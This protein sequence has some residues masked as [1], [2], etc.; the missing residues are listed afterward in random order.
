MAGGRSVRGDVF[1]LIRLLQ[2][3]PTGTN[4]IDRREEGRGR[5]RRGG[6]AGSSSRQPARAHG[7]QESNGCLA[8]AWGFGRGQSTRSGDRQR[9]CGRSIEL[10]VAKGSVGSG[11][12][13][14]QAELAP[15]GGLRGSGSS[16]LPGTRDCPTRSTKRKAT[17]SALEAA[18]AMREQTE[19]GKVRQRE[20]RRVPLRTKKSLGAIF[21]AR[22]WRAGRAACGGREVARKIGCRVADGWIFIKEKE[23][24]GVK[25][26][27][28]V[29]VGAVG[30]NADGAGAQRR[31]GDGTG[32]SE[33]SAARSCGRAELGMATVRRAGIGG[34]E[35]PGGAAAGWRKADEAASRR[36]KAGGC[37]APGG[38]VG[39]ADCRLRKRSTPSRASAEP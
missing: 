1:V 29:M 27:C 38:P 13:S 17:E 21:V 30:R 3:D 11:E 22:F 31:G 14:G 18:S 15:R 2:E 28:K 6:Q 4:W 7:P 23:E 25:E 9:K 39:R 33:S 32:S 12:E 26:S 34:W 19:Q 37:T 10:G 20:A 5:E 8:A 16:P 35:R 36:G 24:G